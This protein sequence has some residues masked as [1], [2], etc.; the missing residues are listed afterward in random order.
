MNGGQQ[1]VIDSLVGTGLGSYGILLIMMFIL[2][3][4]GMFLDWVGI[5][6]LAVPIFVPLMRQL[7]WDGLFGLPG[8]APE[9]GAPLVR[10]RVHGQHADVVSKSPFRVRP[11]LSQKRCTTLGQHG[12]HLSLRLTVSLSTGPRLVPM[13]SLSGNRALATPNGLRKII[14]PIVSG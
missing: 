7:P 8:V 2:V 14:S 11:L 9:E 12:D 10:C 5:L 6:L 1:F 3:A 4:L 13:C